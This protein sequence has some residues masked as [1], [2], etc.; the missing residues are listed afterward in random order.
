MCAHLCETN[1]N[2]VRHGCANIATTTHNKAI[3]ENVE[4]FVHSFFTVCRDAVNA[5][6]A[7]CGLAM[8]TNNATFFEQYSGE[9][10][11]KIGE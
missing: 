11:W 5:I 1:I 10:Q 3:I 2:E 9:F 6:G 4:D 7:N 8:N